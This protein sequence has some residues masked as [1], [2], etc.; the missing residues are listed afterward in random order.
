V[1]HNA[2]NRVADVA[3]QPPVEPEERRVVQLVLQQQVKLGQAQLLGQGKPDVVQEG[4]A[5]S[6][7]RQRDNFYLVPR[8]L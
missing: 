7:P 5:V 1:V 3:A 4:T 2:D 8:R 6:F